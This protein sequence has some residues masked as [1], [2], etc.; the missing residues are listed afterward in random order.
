PYTPG[1]ATARLAALKL[2]EK[3]GVSV[4]VENRPGGSGTLGGQLL[5][6][7]PADG[8]TIMGSASIHPRAK[9]VMKSVPYDPVGDS[10]RSP[11]PRAAPACW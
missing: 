6:Q 8:Y 7:A 9:Y 4:V 3:L 11:A 10:C 2:Q 5:L 1:A